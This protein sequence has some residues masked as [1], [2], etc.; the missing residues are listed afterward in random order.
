MSKITQTKWLDFAKPSRDFNPL[1]QSQDSTLLP[2]I[3]STQMLE[4]KFLNEL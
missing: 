4:R 3:S 2:K 1:E